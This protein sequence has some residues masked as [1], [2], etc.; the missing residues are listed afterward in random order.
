M[1]KLNDP[2]QPDIDSGRL[3]CPFNDVLVSKN[4]YFVVCRESQKDIGKIEAF[5]NWLLDMVESEQE[6]VKDGQVT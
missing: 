1:G 4:A 3:I 5:R 2:N 6:Q